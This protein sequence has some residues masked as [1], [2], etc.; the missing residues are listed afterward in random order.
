MTG[1]YG[2]YGNHPQNQNP[3]YGPPQRPAPAR[4]EPS[5]RPA[6]K[7]RGGGLLVGAVVAAALG[8]V[9]IVAGVLFVP[10]GGSE[11]SGGGTN[12]DSP[13]TVAQKYIDAGKQ[14]D[15]ATMLRLTCDKDKA[16][17]DTSSPQAQGEGGG[18]VDYQLLDVQQTGDTAT[19]SVKITIAGVSTTKAMPLVKE[20]GAWKVCD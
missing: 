6:P 17:V 13:Q 11:G 19:A 9:A 5:G 7:R 16:S 15:S 18:S 4:R 3:Q 14:G 12:A 20:N 8:V 2:G 1:P 10:H